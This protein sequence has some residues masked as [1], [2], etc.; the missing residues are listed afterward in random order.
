[1][2]FSGKGFLPLDVKPFL[3]SSVTPAT[4]V[5]ALTRALWIFVSLLSFFLMYLSHSAQ[6]SSLHLG[7]IT[8][9]QLLGVMLL[10][11]DSVIWDW[12]GKAFVHNAGQFA[13]FQYWA[14]FAIW[15][16]GRFNGG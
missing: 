7:T 10:C 12:V 5:E 11:Y 15:P 8:D 16:N 1:M 4:A 3:S 9:S 14:Q 2:S 6:T 13:V